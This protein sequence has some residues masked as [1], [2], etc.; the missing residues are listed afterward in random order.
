MES[1]VDGQWKYYG[2]KTEETRIYQKV[3]DPKRFVATRLN[4]LQGDCKSKSLET[5]LKLRHLGAVRKRGKRPHVEDLNHP[6]EW[7]FWV[8]NKG[9]VFDLSGGVTQIIDAQGYYK[10]SN[11]QMIQTPTCGCLFNDELDEIPTQDKKIWKWV[12]ENITPETTRAL[13]KWVKSQMDEEQEILEE[14]AD[15]LNDLRPEQMKRMC[16]IAED[17]QYVEKATQSFCEQE[18][19]TEEELLGHSKEFNFHRGKLTDVGGH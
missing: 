8:E 17:R 18:G 5:W 13:Q 14:S 3:N 4:F 11:M 19:I 10:A 15:F 12:C 9:K 16:S 7:H 1:I 2:V 6:K